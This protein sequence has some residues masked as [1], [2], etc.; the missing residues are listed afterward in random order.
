MGRLLTKV[1]GTRAA[2]TSTYSRAGNRLTE[3]STI[4]GDPGN[5]TATTGYDPLDR[6]TGYALPGRSALHNSPT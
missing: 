1:T 4:T 5:E 6:L 2:Y 3:T